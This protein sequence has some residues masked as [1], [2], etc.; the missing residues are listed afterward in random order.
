MLRSAVEAVQ[1]LLGHQSIDVT[2]RY[3]HLSPAA[4]NQAILESIADGVLVA[5]SGG[6]IALANNATSLI[7]DLPRSELEGKSMADMLGR[8]NA[9]PASWQTAIEEW[10]TQRKP[11]SGRVALTDEFQIAGKVISVTLSPVHSGGQFFGTVS[12]FRDITHAVELDQMK[13]DFVSTVSHEL[14]T[15]MTSIKGYAD[16]M[17]MGAAGP[18]AASQARYLQ[19]IKNNA[20]RL[21][22]LVNDLLDISR[23]ETGKT[24]L[25]LRPLDL[26][27]LIEQVVHGHLQ[28]RI[29]HEQKSLDLATEYTPSLPLVQGDH[30]RVTQI[31]NNLLDNAFNYTPAGGSITV[32][33]RANNR[34]VYVSI[35][36]TGIGITPENQQKVFERFFRAGHNEVQAVAGTGLGLS[37]VQSL[38][39]MHGGTLELHS[40]PEKGSTFTF[41][42]PVVE[43][44]AQARPA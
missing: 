21:S 34:F 39:Q 18:V 11:D 15:P 4:K 43:D 16:L 9:F 25:D 32:R 20:D 3:A 22:M 2:L 36:D 14:R 29:Q 28:G 8:Y 27:Q 5:D 10:A 40:E 24:E 19:V 7:L 33:A 38:V 17:L 6:M 35:I 31:L 12:I 30:A 41:S 44:Q 23:F 42:L 1:E 26:T 13:S 37:I